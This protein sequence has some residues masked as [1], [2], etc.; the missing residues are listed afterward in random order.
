VFEA[1]LHR[2]VESLRPASHI[3]LLEGSDLRAILHR[4][5]TLI[6]DAA[7]APQS[8]ALH[9]LI[10]GESARFPKVAA[11]VNR[12][13]AS[14]EGVALIAGLL[15]REAEAGT[16]KVDDPH[17]AAQHFLQMVIAIPQRAAMGL[18][19]PMSEAQLRAWPGQVVAL[20]LEGCRATAPAPRKRG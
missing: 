8:I 18:G 2:V 3:P 20:F 6:L 10:V 9:R 17:F 19:A 16:I 5:A 11:A 15:K 12:N 1:V 4:L 14:E 7:I 13:A